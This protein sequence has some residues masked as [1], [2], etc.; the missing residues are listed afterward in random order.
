MRAGG[1]RPLGRG[2]PDAEHAARAVARRTGGELRWVDALLLGAAETVAIEKKLRGGLDPAIAANDR[3]PDGPAWPRL[4]NLM[5]LAAQRS[6]GEILAAPG[7]LVLTRLGLLARYDLLSAVAEL[8]AAH[9]AP[10]PE[11]GPGRAATLVVLPVYA[12]EGAVVEVGA[13]VAPRVGASAGTLLVPVPGV[14][15]HEIIEVPTAWMERH[16]ER[17]SAGISGFPGAQPG[18]G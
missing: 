8:A 14:L 16:A 5:R 15:P 17:R 13:D 18:L 10:A 9:R 7:L 4:L 2:A 6:V 11:G 1:G 3:G 12:G